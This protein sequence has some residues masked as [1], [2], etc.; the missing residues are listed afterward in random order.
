MI[1]DINNSLEPFK[2]RLLNHDVNRI[3][4]NETKLRNTQQGQDKDKRCLIG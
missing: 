1:S 3:L 4:T 2:Q